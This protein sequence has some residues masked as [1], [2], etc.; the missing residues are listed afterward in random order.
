M[1][2]PRLTSLR[3]PPARLPA[4][5]LTRPTYPKQSSAL[6]VEIENKQKLLRQIKLR[7]TREREEGQGELEKG[8]AELEKEVRAITETTAKQGA[9]SEQRFGNIEESAKVGALFIARETRER[10]EGQGELEKGQAE[11]EKEVCAITETAAEQAELFE[12]RFGNIEESGNVAAL[13]RERETRE[14]VQ[15]QGELKK[16]ICEITETAAEQ[17]EQFEQVQD[18]IEAIL[19]ESSRLNADSVATNAQAAKVMKL[20]NDRVTRVETEH[21]ALANK[22]VEQHHQFEAM[23]RKVLANVIV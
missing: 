18:E 1:E 12:R 14:R 20:V 6:E 9:L 17:A 2:W 3:A 11:L 13:F 22:V 10:E 16:E 19:E 5:P 21:D 4:R 8:Q 15:G 7:E 23:V